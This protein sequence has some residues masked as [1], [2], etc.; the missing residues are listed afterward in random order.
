MNKEIINEEENVEN[1]IEQAKVEQA[2]VE[3]TEVEQ[4]NVE[5]TRKEQFEEIL[6]KIK[7]MSEAIELHDNVKD[8]VSKEEVDYNY[9]RY[10]ENSLEDKLFNNANTAGIMPKVLL[11]VVCP[12]LV[13]IENFDE[14]KLQ[15]E[16]IGSH[17]EEQENYIDKI[18][19]YENKLICVFGISEIHPNKVIKYESRKF[20]RV[21]MV[22]AVEAQYEE[23][24]TVSLYQYDE[25]YIGIEQ[26]RI[27]VFTERKIT[28][29]AKVEETIFDKIKTKLSKIFTKKKCLYP[30]LELVFDSNPNRLKDF[31]HKSKFDAKTRMRVLLNKEREITR[32]E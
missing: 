2:K 3:Y 7:K 20:S 28:A 4:V 32:A 17:F 21:D 5:K 9:L 31:E 16:N 19:V 23:G 25:Y 24:Q 12:D 29:L 15:I 14:N 10:V 13:N 8:A 6:E 22:E 11:E 26:E 27:K 18:C 30:N 1:N